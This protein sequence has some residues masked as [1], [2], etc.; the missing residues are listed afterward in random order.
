MSR[1]P[2][3]N[4]A[5]LGAG[6]GRA[7]LKAYLALPDLFHVVVL[8]DLDQKRA[9]Q[10]V[11]EEAG[12]KT[13]IAI[14][15][16]VAE[17]LGR[18]DIDLVNICLPP[19]LHFPMARDAMLAGKHVV[20]EKP[21]VTSLS[22]ADA[23]IEVAK[24]TGKILSPVFQYRFG[25]AMSQ[26]IALQKSGLAGR[27]YAA[28]LETHWDRG[29]DYYAVDWRG[30][31]KHENGGAV[32]GHAIHN[33]DLLTSIL[34]PISRLSAHTSTL[35]NPIEVEDCAA[36]SFEM[37][38]GAVATSSITLG[39][40]SNTS[41]LRFAFERLTAQSGTA[42]YAPMA[43]PWTFEARHKEEQER[44]DEVVASVGNVPAGFEGYF[45]ELAKRIHGQDTR[46]VTIEDGRRSIELVAA[47]YQSAREKTTLQLP[48]G[49]STPLYESWAPTR[50]AKQEL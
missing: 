7:H 12:E 28:S 2:L 5:I 41:R 17:V 43:D 24:S 26:L 32:L 29:S 22:E 39:A 40:A 50:Q 37:E 18:M 27:A 10:V 46:A 49:T 14:A 15:T 47:I 30:T 19:H 6:I 36:I 42:P 16:D 13:E 8:C 44:I 4:V 48:L 34:G 33:H 25:P 35:V 3:I 21:M 20:C 9:E 45:A 38:S 1:A 23:L 31:W 11:R